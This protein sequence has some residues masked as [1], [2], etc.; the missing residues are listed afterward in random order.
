MDNAGR[1]VIGQL[2]DAKSMDA[3]ARLAGI[4]TRKL[5]PTQS[6]GSPLIKVAVNDSVVIAKSD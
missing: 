4:P 2:M 3:L 6:G 5:L 1:K